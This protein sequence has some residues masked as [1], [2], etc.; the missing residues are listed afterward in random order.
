MSLLK[1]NSV[2]RHLARPDANI[3]GS[4]FFGPEAG[5]VA[6]RA[7]ALTHYY[8]AK[9][10]QI[11][12]ISEEKYKSDGLHLEALLNADSLF[13]D[14][15]FYL[16]EDGGPDLLSHLKEMDIDKLLGLPHRFAIL[17]GDLKGTSGLRKF[18][19]ASSHLAAIACYLDTHGDIIKLVQDTLQSQSINISHENASYVASLLGNN[20]LLNRSELEKLSLYCLEMGEVSREAIDEVLDDNG[21][22]KIDA[23]I[24]ACFNGQPTVL[25]AEMQRF[26]NGGLAEEMLF[27]SL[28][29]HVEG[30]YAANIL[31]QSGQS[32]EL[33]LNRGFGYIHFS[34]KTDLQRQLSRWSLS[35]LE[36]A[37]KGLH[38]LENNLRLNP[39]LK[40][41]YLERYFL[42]LAMIA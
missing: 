21:V 26:F 12:R 42:R 41:S 10:Y 3:L 32:A 5:L 9:N 1:G 2:D 30:L 16:L 19:E 28:T 33:S 20:R 22:S 17:A 39:E 4:L 37:Q 27:A 11:T 36:H 15:D 23:L 18:F 8:A 24:D 25:A 40:P 6:E 34:R 35:K 14:N 31:Q 38:E 13:A 29:R 7:A